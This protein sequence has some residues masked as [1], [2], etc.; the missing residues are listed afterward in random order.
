MQIMIDIKKGKL[1]ITI[2]RESPEKFLVQL[3]LSLLSSVQRMANSESIFNDPDTI[4]D[5]D[6]FID[7]QKELSL[8]L[9]QL[10]KVFPKDKIKLSE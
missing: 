5:M 2:K 9:E 4:S 10:E 1:I 7:L 8:S 3:N 6:V